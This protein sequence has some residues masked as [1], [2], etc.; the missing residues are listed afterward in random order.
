MA[1]LRGNF[2]RRFDLDAENL[3]APRGHFLLQEIDARFDQPGCVV[4]SNRR[5]TNK[6]VHAVRAS[7]PVN[8]A[9][10]GVPEQ[11]FRKNA[12]IGK[13]YQKSSPVHPH[14]ANPCKNAKIADN[15]K[16]AS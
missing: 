7:D 1:R 15:R 8:Q 10:L 16:H 11:E 6:R 3:R 5:K 9:D 2:P 14:A 13:I 12:D 4:E